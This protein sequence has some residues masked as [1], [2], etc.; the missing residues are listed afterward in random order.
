MG[1]WSVQLA[2]SLGYTPV[3][4]CSEPAPCP[5]G[6]DFADGD[7]WGYRRFY[8]LSKLVS[9]LLFPVP[10]FSLTFPPLRP[11]SMRMDSFA[12]TP[13]FS[14][15]AFGLRPTTRS[16]KISLCKCSTLLLTF[17]TPLYCG[18]L[19]CRLLLCVGTSNGWKTAS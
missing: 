9:R 10:S 2:S 3:C 1:V 6:S 12:R 11:L 13:W 4:G 17:S 14:G 5:T 19:F 18:S 15:S 16:A 7:C 8:R